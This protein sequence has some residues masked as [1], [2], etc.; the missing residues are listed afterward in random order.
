ERETRC[1]VVQDGR[2]ADEGGDDVG[3]ERVVDPGERVI[4]GGTVE[5]QVLDCRLQRDRP[6]RL[7]TELSQADR[8]R[9]DRDVELERCRRAEV[10]RVPG[11][12]DA[13]AIVAGPQAAEV[14]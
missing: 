8:G 9:L 6:D 2:R 1:A 5:R 10:T 14:E 7:G 12:V 4:A 11:V 13:K 3:R